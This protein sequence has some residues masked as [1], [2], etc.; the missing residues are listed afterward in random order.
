MTGILS[1]GS[2]DAGQP[3]SS[4]IN[5]SVCDLILIRGRQSRSLRYGKASADKKAS[6]NLSMHRGPPSKKVRQPAIGAQR[7]KEGTHS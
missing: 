2:A 7:T 3:W 4:R 6:Q 1:L 5:V